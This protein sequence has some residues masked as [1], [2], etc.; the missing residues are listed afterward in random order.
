MCT[1]KDI[2]QNVY[3]L[4]V[5]LVSDFSVRYLF[6]IFF[7]SFDVSWSLLHVLNL[8]KFNN[9]PVPFEEDIRPY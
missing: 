2:D 4:S 6:Q 7:E 8:F 9:D 1:V 5:I 3:V